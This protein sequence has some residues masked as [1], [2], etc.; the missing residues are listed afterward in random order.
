MSLTMKKILILG[1][2]FV[3]KPVVKYLAEKK[4]NIT[5]ADIDLQKAKESA[6]QYTNVSPLQF[7]IKDIAKLSQFIENHDLV[8]SLLPVAFHTAVAENCVENGKCMVT[9]S[10]VSEKMKL[11]DKPAKHA[12]VVIINEVGVDPGIDHMSAMRVIH[13][14]RQKGGYIESFMSYCGGLPSPDFNDNPFGYKFSWSPKGVLTAGKS[15]GKYLR[16]GEV[17]YVPGDLLFTHYWITEIPG[18]GDFEA[19]PNRNSLNY[20]DKYNLEKAETMFRGTLRNKGWC[21]TM[22]SITELGY[23]DESEADW[24]GKTYSD[25]SRNLLNNGNIPDLRKAVASQLNMEADSEIIERMEWLGL[26]SDD[27]IKIGHGSPLDILTDR[28][29]EKMVYLP[30]ETDMLILSHH[31]LAKYP[32]GKTE[33]ITSTLIDYGVPGGN[34]SMSR[35]VGYPAAIAAD[36]IASGRFKTPGVHI[37]VLP[38]LYNPILEELEKLNISCK[39]ESRLLMK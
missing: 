1:A 27:K 11:L 21:D 13:K 14:V 37:P 16:D 9:T 5:L 20:I 36:L 18:A 15:D 23:L 33:E 2:G 24:K 4:Y 8:V 6:A 38:E 3:S 17:I 29:T 22:K 12:G 35:T 10:Y 28:M 32:E 26:F 19:Y 25:L 34:S 30:G 39:E 31:F 7:D